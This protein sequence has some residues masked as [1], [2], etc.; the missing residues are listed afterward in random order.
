M[1]RPALAAIITRRPHVFDGLLDPALLAEL[2]NRA[3]LAGRLAAF[4]Q[5]VTAHEEVLDRLRIFASEQK[6]LI[7]V[8]LLA[9][10]IDADPR[11]QGVFAISP[12]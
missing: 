7:G 6:F 3:Y 12:I 2:P 4:L 1:R 8:R 10:T 9:G 5:N 11:G